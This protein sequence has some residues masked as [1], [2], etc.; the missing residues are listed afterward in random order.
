MGWF[1]EEHDEW[2]DC[3]TCDGKRYAEFHRPD[4]CLFDNDELINSKAHTGAKQKRVR[5][6]GR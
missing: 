4:D 5:R 2:C 3:D 6:D 1:Y